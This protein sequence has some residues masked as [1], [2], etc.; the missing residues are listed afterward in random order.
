MLNPS[1][2]MMEGVY[3]DER[4]NSGL[5]MAMDNVEYEIG[6]ETDSS[7]LPESAIDVASLLER[8]IAK[9]PPGTFVIFKLPETESLEESIDDDVSILF[10]NG[11]G[12]VPGLSFME[13]EDGGFMQFE[14]GG[15][16][17]YEN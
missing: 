9:V 2:L 1:Q 5:G 13:F 3:P 10:G 12:I 15:Q 14:D 17:A 8:I 16:M 7:S 4:F 6:D 11:T